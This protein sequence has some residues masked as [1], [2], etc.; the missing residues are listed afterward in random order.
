MNETTTEPLA[1]FDSDEAKWAAVL[2][3]VAAADGAFV[4]AVRTTGIYCRPTCPSRRPRREN[5][6]F[7]ADAAAAERAG[8]RPCQRCRPQEAPLTQRNAER[9]ARA[10]R[11]IEAAEDL[12]SLDELAQA[13]GLSRFHFHRVFKSVTGLTPKAYGVACRAERVRAELLNSETVTDAIYDAGFNSS[14]RFYAGSTQILGMTPKCYRSGGEG[15]EIRFA[16]GE[17]SLGAIL[18]AASDKGLCA[19][20]L[21]NDPE[22]LLQEFQDRF[23]NANLVPGGKDFDAWVA[24]VVG[25]V[26]AP[27][28]GLSLP[29]DIRGTAFQQRVWQALTEIPVGHTIS[30][31]ELAERIGSPKSVRAVASACAANSIALAIPCHRVVRSDGALSGYRWGVE[32]KRTL[33]EREAAL[34]DAAVTE[35]LRE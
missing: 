25:F 27:E 5:A 19:I 1:A 8:Y 26:E 29:L 20:S 9:I 31:K 17:C 11:R 16:L 12:P 15:L 4:Y 30:Y 22:A 14:G 6:E 2:A 3:R 24:R 18:V 34:V 28:V 35:N 33:L 21:G 23:A 13:A 7:H 32:R 10:C